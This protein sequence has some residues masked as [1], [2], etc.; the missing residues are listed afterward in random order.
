MELPQLGAHD[1]GSTTPLAIVGM[2]LEF[3]QDADNV[4]SFWQM[5]LAGRCASTKFPS[6]RFNIDAFYH[7]GDDRPSTIPVRGGHFLK[8]DLGAFDAPFFSITANEAAC[9]DPQHRR[10]LET[11]YHALEDGKLSCSEHTVYYANTFPAGISL[12]KCTGSPTSVY[13]GCFTNDYLSILQQDYES[14]QRHA[15][16]GLVP[17]MM[18]NRLSWFFNFKGSSMVSNLCFLSIVQLP[19]FLKVPPEL[20]RDCR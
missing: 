12:N 14:E 19:W 17:S 9:M 10:M 2:A 6:D 15:A 8:E 11:A 18:A 7:P 3:P 16:M 13:T 20:K 5:I 1:D 4:E